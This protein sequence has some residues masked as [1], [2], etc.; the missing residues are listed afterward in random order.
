MANCDGC[1]SQWDNKQT[2]PVGSFAANAFG[3]YDMIGNVWEWTEDC[4]HD[5]Y[6][7]APTDG[8]AWTSG[9]YT[10]RVVRGGSWGSYPVFL[11]SAIRFRY[12][13][14]YRSIYLGFRIAR[15]LTP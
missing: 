5:N 10:F 1:G 9:D 6:R 8:S 7:G 14:G 13:A 11:R 3:L 2:A 12:S 4:W 15:T